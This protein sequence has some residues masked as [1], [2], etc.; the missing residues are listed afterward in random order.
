M[1]QPC[2]GEA[3]SSFL[4]LFSNSVSNQVISPGVAMEE[5]NMIDLFFPAAFLMAG[6]LY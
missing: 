6:V 4:P 2:E 3:V 5:V 1:T